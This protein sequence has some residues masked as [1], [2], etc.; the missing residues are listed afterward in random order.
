MQMSASLAEFTARLESGPSGLQDA[1]AAVSAA[2]ASESA[3]LDLQQMH[4]TDADLAALIPSLAPLAQH[5]RD[6]NLFLNALT[7][8]PA[9]VAAALPGLERLRAG[10][11]ALSCIDDAAFSGLSS[12]VE[13]DVG[14]SERLETLPGSIGDCKALRVLHAGNGRIA[15][16]PSE[17]FGCASLEEL[18]LYG[19]SLAELPASIGKL[20][21]LRV[22]SVGRNQLASLPS[23]LALCTKLTTLHVYENNL[24]R[25]PASFA[26]LP[27]LKII[28][29]EN[30]MD[31]LPVPR[32]VRLQCSA[33]AVAAFYCSTQ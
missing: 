9:G 5:V 26:N 16:L 31:L 22:L 33:P 2:A 18:H 24:S 27:S 14:F 25:F 21:N 4:L 17:L 1:K 15:T 11:N 7:V 23:E 8:L 20:R 6:L 28:N 13:L 19:N 3:V 30:N 12:L 32:E 10:A 29:A